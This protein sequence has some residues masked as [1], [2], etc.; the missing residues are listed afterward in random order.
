MT[1]KRW[2][3]WTP[4]TGTEEF[5]T[6]AEAKSWIRDEL[7]AAMKMAAEYGVDEFNDPT[8]FWWGEVRG[9]VVE[10]EGGPIPCLLCDAEHGEPHDSICVHSGT[11][12]TDDRYVDYEL[13]PYPED[14]RV[15]Q[16]RAALRDVWDHLPTELWRNLKI[17][18]MKELAK[19][20]LE[21]P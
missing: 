16:L 1:D 2:V 5:G 14:P 9:R 3:T 10:I 17:E 12:G 6:E 8:S 11:H 21:R 18:T 4:D 20:H 19:L 7:D 15:E 13:Q